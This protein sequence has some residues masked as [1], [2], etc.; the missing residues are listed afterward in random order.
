[1]KQTCRKV[2]N[3]LGRNKTS[4]GN[5]WLDLPKQSTL[6]NTNNS[7][8][9]FTDLTEW[10][11][12]TVQSVITFQHMS[13]SKSKISLNLTSNLCLPTS[14]EFSLFKYVSTIR[15]NFRLTKDKVMKL[16][17][18]LLFRNYS[19]SSFQKR[20]ELSKIRWRIASNFNTR[21]LMEV[22]VISIK[23]LILKW[24]N[25]QKEKLKISSSKNTSIFSSQEMIL[26]DCHPKEFL[27]AKSNKKVT[28]IQAKVTL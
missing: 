5:G 20:R 2:N 27:K 6:H 13:S 21:V 25:S 26:C 14:T 1:M 7:E 8:I 12:V 18:D 15:I 3:C 28:K 19:N 23:V 9:L 10:S 17:S 22:K 16:E 24:W 4:S 11:T